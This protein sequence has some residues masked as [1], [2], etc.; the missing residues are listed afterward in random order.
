[1]PPIRISSKHARLLAGLSLLLLALTALVLWHEAEGARPWK[2]FQRAFVS[3][4]QGITASE[5]AQA[6]GQ[7]DNA[8]K[9]AQL[10]LL[11][12]RLQ[13]LGCQA[14]AIRQLWLPEL[15]VSD[16]CTTCHLGVESPR[17]REA[18]QP[19]RS[20]PDRHLA[21]DRHPVERFGCVS[22]HDGQDVA[23]TVADAHGET[24]PWLKPVLRGELAEAS[25]R[26]CHGYDDKVPAHIAFPEAPHL[27]NGKNLYL[28]KG[29]MGC[30]VVQGF[31]RQQRIG[32]I[33]DRVAEKAADG[34][35][36][37]WIRQPKA[38]LPKTI[39]PFFDLNEGESA[40]LTAFLAARRGGTQPP[41]ATPGD[42]GR[43]KELLHEVG[44]LACHAVGDQGGSFGPDLSRVAEKLTGPDW[45]W[46]WLGDP[47][48]YD[49]ETAMPNFR[50]S[51]AQIADL[52]AYLLTLRR[53]EPQQFQ[54][55]PALAEEGKALFTTL[56]CTGCHKVEGLPY[57]FP[58]SPEHTGFADK[59]MEMF[60]FGHVG[61]I[62]RTRAAWTAKKLVQ[63]RAFS[64]ET[65]KLVMPDFALS[66]DERRDLRVFLLSLAAREAPVKYQKPFW[67]GDDPLLTGMRTVEKYNCTG[68]HKF[69]LTSREIDLRELPENDYLWAATTVVLEDVTAENG[70]LWR[71]GAQLNEAQA[72][73]LLAADPEAERSLFRQRWFIDEDSAAYL[74]DAGIERLPVLGLGEGDIVGLY[75]D[76]NF[77]PPLLHHEGRKAQPDWLHAFLATPYPVRPLTKATMPTF[78][79]T[80]AERSG[81]V[82]FFTAKEGLSAH[83]YCA[84][85]EL[86]LKQ[87][88]R[89]EA[90][91]KLCLQCHAFDQQR[92]ADKAGFEDL[93][94]PNLAEVK[95][96]LRPDYIRDW[97]RFPELVI[98][99][100]Q[101]KNFFYDF[102]IDNRFSE[103]GRD[104][105]GLS[106]I[107]PEEK[108]ELMAR[109]LMNPFKNARLSV[110]R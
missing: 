13:G 11:D 90:V 57:G 67:Q 33:L 91:F 26:R 5:R 110:Q 60:D 28:D 18:A 68:C 8:E 103:I 99:G 101:M 36:R 41:A 61:D 106:D 81:L 14:V 21:A 75:K 96:R 74:L 7:A 9:T 27:T 89:A 83:P 65:I 69:G 34:W 66:D 37:D 63:P 4:D 82:A 79:L 43:G 48:A 45:L 25:C 93:K 95:R 10:A 12:Q 105:T 72:T 108:I 50:L 49:R 32:P 76:L 15:G 77:A 71:K 22:C 2:K 78:N 44:C 35:I 40:R 39:M 98:P 86:D 42:V 70:T 20:H 92:I 54:A 24:A 30:H 6:A 87:T 62:P 38:Y 23:L 88:T 84:I 1:M 52:N 58:R 80:A 46:H 64:T 53:Q 94:G 55:D 109:F 31:E 107:S 97:V 19:F 47:A 104:E 73:A 16:R 102:D 85:D 56:G 17:F 51:P 29:C 59:G 100:T 3:L